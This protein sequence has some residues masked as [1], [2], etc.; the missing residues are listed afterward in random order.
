MRLSATS[1]GQILTRYTKKQDSGALEFETRFAF[2][3]ITHYAIESDRVGTV[4]DPVFRLQLG[5]S[6]FGSEMLDEKPELAVKF[7]NGIT[8]KHQ[9]SPVARVSY[10][11]VYPDLDGN[12]DKQLSDHLD[13]VDMAPVDMISEQFLPAC[14]QITR[15]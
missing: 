1:P 14:P 7:D 11:C 10:D 3:I 4:A 15:R 6:V 2:D 5:K 12:S 9:E 13:I 8:G